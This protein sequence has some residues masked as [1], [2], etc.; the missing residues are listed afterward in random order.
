MNKARV[1][2]FENQT[3]LE[4][5]FF[6]VLSVALIVLSVSMSEGHNWMMSPGLFPLIMSC[7]LLFLGFLLVVSELRSKKVVEQQ[8]NTKTEGILNGATLKLLGIMIFTAIMY[9]FIMKFIGFFVTSFI[10]LCCMMLL[11]GEKRWHI[12]LI[13]AI[14]TCA[15]IYVLFYRFLG[16]MLPTLF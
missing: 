16:V 13:V 12:V 15:V 11:M 9:A 2:V 1:S 3:L 4:G 10:Y 6:I 14:S 7:L 8:K 5:L